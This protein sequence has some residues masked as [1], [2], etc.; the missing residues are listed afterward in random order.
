MSIKLTVSNSLKP[1]AD[2][3][4]QNLNQLQKNPFSK[5]WIITQTEGMNNWLKYGIAERLGIIAN[6]QFYRPNDVLSIVYRLAGG[7]HKK[8]LDQEIMKWCLYTL[9]DNEQFIQ[10]H[11]S[12]SLYYANDNIKKIALANEMA[13]LF[14]QYQLYRPE[15]IQDWN[16]E[17]TIS[18]TSSEWQMHLWILL[19]KQLQDKYHDKTEMGHL[20]LE[21]I[22]NPDF[23]EALR[24]KIPAL[25]FFGLAIIA[26]YYLNL[27]NQLGNVIDIY[28]YM[29]NP[30]PEQYWLEDKSEKQIA[31]LSSKNKKSYTEEDHL[32]A[33]N[34]LLLN[35]GTI[36]KNTYTILF[37]KEE[38]IN[39]YDELL[40]VPDSQPLTLLKKIQADIYHNTPNNLRVGYTEDDTKDG[41]I[42]IHGCYTPLREVEV[43][44]N[45]FLELIDRK[46]VQLSPRDIVVMVSD[47]DF[48]APF[49]HAIFGNS[50]NAFPYKIADETITA[51]NNMFAALKAILNIDEQTLKAENVLDLL[52]YTYIRNRFKIHSI[53]NI[54]QAVREAGIF[55]GDQGREEDETYIVSWKYGL[56]KILYGLCIAGSP[57]DFTVNSRSL[58]PLDTAEGAEGMERIKLIH[59]YQVLT[60]YLNDRKT[61]KTI[62]EWADYLKNL[63]EDMVFQSAE[64]EDEDYP[65]FITLIENLIELDE[66]NTL[67]ISF[68]VFRHSLLSRLIT[69]KK[70]HSFSTVGITFCSLVPMRSIPFKVVGLLGM[71]F[72]KFPRKETPLSFSI[73]Q[74]EKKLG[75]RNI[76]E[77]DK[78]LFLETV[79]SADEYLYISYIAK[80]SKD[81]TSIPPSSLVDELIDY[82]ARAA[83]AETEKLKEKW[84]VTHPLHGFSKKYFDDSGMLNYLSEAYFKTNIN[85][86]ADKPTSILTID[87]DEIQLND[88]IAFFH[89]P[90]KYFLNKR[91]KVYYN[92]KEEIIP[93]HEV[94]DIDSLQTWSIK[95]ELLYVPDDQ[96]EQFVIE[97]K[98]SGKFPLANM[99]TVAIKNISDEVAALKS[100]FLATVENKTQQQIDIRLS[101]GSSAIKGT[102]DDV[103]DNSLVE[104]CDST[105]YPKYLIRAY[106]KYLIMK[107]SDINAEIIFIY[108]V[109]SGIYSTI[110]FDFVSKDDAYRNLDKLIKLYK[111]AFDNYFPFYPALAKNQYRKA[112]YQ[113]YA[114]EMAAVVANE[115]NND[116]RDIYFNKAFEH[117]FINESNFALLQEN[118][119]L[120]FGQLREQQPDLFK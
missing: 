65:V 24:N 49:I 98:L 87:Y 94:F 99:G 84:I 47:I 110:N 8:L 34:D 38:I 19:K 90:P 25:H 78:H 32:L 16:K 92:E 14:D 75:D 64:K 80:E 100:C 43:L 85:L 120:M 39:N 116:F 18:P 21:A 82:T 107:A 46:G 111:T 9:L 77:N 29:T 113:E 4:A 109:K 17:D 104:L 5:Q 58:I 79:L 51:G 45:Y 63:L 73:M 91:L 23:Q 60:A 6:V 119:E 69:E 56:E 36:V 96:T 54:R 117:Q 97:K 3:I 86:P 76:K 15:I 40:V 105:D 42:T 59:F 108:K 53:K 118:I 37:E 66:E 12:I 67:K 72:N 26:P 71:D 88:F 41:S 22:N 35:W 102:I 68:D 27:L 33:G 70:S 1:L 114:E 81:G 103:Y 50:K 62:A 52:D 57:T 48:Y 11:Q 106:I 20:L 13:D 31:R 101:I 74:R 28:F 95:R 30:A 83:N 44:Y 61:D 93:E 55:W 10:Q 89:N 112:S 115:Y 2:T 7:A